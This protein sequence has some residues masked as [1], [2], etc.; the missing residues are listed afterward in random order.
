MYHQRLAFDIIQRFQSRSD[1]SRR[2]IPLIIN[3]QQW[4]ISHVSTT[5]GAFML[6]GFMR[7][8]MSTC[9]FGGRSFTFFNSWL[10]TAVS[11]HMKAMLS[12]RQSFQI[13]RKLQPFRRF[14]NGH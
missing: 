7:V 13:W 8:K 9:R 3:H 10:T 1:D 12:R 6:T 2:G 11:M 14:R 5:L 4:E